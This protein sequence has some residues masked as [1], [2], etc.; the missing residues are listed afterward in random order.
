MLTKKN[1]KIYYVF[2]VNQDV[3]MNC[4]T[5]YSHTVHCVLIQNTNMKQLKIFE[6]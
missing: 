1:P 3:T 6:E 2:P 4:V 5:S